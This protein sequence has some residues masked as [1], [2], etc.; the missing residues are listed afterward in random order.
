M[1][2]NTQTTQIR[3]ERNFVLSASVSL[4][5]KQLEKWNKVEHALTVLSKQHTNSK[6]PICVKLYL[7]SNLLTYIIVITLTPA[8]PAYKTEAVLPRTGKRWRAMF[9][10]F[11]LFG[12]PLL[13]LILFPWTFMLFNSRLSVHIPSTCVNRLRSALLC[14]DLLVGIQGCNWFASVVL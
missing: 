11:I 12:Q 4:Q 2:E 7:F 9:G 1:G 14:W 8:L 5:R 10:N 6:L 3:T 13:Y